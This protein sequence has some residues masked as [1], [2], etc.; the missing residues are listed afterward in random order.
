MSDEIIHKIKRIDKM[1][2]MLLNEEQKEE[3]RQFDI[4]NYELKLKELE[5]RKHIGSDSLERQIDNAV[6]AS[7]GNDSKYTI[8]R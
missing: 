7:M 6:Y 3:I 1:L 4:K 5:K 8:V 2:Y